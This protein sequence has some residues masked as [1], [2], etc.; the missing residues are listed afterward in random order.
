VTSELGR[1][2]ATDNEG[3]QFIVAPSMANAAMMRSEYLVNNINRSR[4]DSIDREREF[5]HLKYKKPDEIMS[6][7]LSVMKRRREIQAAKEQSFFENFSK[8]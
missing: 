4:H 7:N 2:R 1:T 8:T 6:R 5:K 3:N